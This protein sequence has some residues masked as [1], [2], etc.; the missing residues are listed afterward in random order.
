MEL[1]EPKESGKFVIEK[2][3][4]ISISVD[5]REF[6]TMITLSGLFAAMIVGLVYYILL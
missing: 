6:W 4:R 5:R 2:I 1:N 3:K